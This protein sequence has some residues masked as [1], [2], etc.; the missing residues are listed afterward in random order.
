ML[1]SIF[2]QPDIGTG[3][4]SECIWVSRMMWFLSE[5]IYYNLLGIFNYSLQINGR[6]LYLGIIR[7]FFVSTV[8]IIN[9][10]FLPFLFN[11]INSGP[12]MEE[13]RSC[14][15]TKLTTF[16]RT[17]DLKGPGIW[18][19]FSITQ[20][21]IYNFRAVS[22]SAIDILHLA[23]MERYLMWEIRCNFTIHK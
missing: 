10:P 9:C 2:N 15:E 18:A 16:A 5:F 19:A 6:G 23:P 3:S 8:K 14:K 12:L 1:W 20:S 11:Y 17:S 13:S 4:E 7:F 22:C 21:N